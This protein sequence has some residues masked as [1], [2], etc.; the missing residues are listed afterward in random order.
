MYLASKVDDKR[1][2]PLSHIGFTGLFE[3]LRASAMKRFFRDQRLRYPEPKVQCVDDDREEQRCTRGKVRLRNEENL[4]SVKAKAGETNAE[5]MA[6]HY[7]LS[8]S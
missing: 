2:A 1:K 7:I 5:I 4:S 8:S 3:R 6:A